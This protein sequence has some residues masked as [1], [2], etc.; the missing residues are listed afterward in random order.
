MKLKPI[1][2]PSQG[3]TPAISLDLLTLFLENEKK[4][5]GGNVLEVDY[6]RGSAVATVTFEDAEGQFYVRPKQMS[7]GSRSIDTQLVYI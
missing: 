4:S 1:P 3:L 6:I 2:D 5:G 7:F